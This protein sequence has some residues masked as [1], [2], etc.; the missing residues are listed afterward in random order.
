VGWTFFWLMV[1]MKIP[2]VA[3]ILLVWW[4]VRAVPEPVVEEDAR[5]GD[6]EGG[7]K[8]PASHLP[9]PRRPP[10][11]RGPHGSPTLPSPP[12]VRRRAAA[13]PRLPR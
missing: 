2:I 4:A 7:S 9:K 3:L 12:R 5:G 6:D 1:I 13:R 8:V 10:R 11:P